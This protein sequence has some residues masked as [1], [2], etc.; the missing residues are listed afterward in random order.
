MPVI[1]RIN[2]LTVYI[3]AIL[4]GVK[5]LGG[6]KE[7]LSPII[8]KK[9]CVSLHF[10]IHV[11]FFNILIYNCNGSP[12]CGKHAQN[13]VF[14]TILQLSNIRLG[15]PLPITNVESA[16]I[17]I[18]LNQF[19]TFRGQVKIKPH[20]NAG[21]IRSDSGCFREQTLQPLHIGPV[22]FESEHGFGKLKHRIK[23]SL[24]DCDRVF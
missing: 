7:H 21:C 23:I 6:G 5:L 9:C 18:D 24:R 14:K 1:D 17:V 19:W 22:L 10:G 12:G 16:C 3:E 4:I 11:L 2:T 13:P 15:Q 20:Q 8:G